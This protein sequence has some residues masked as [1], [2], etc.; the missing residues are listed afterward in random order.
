MQNPTSNVN[1]RKILRADALWLVAAFVLGTL[2]GCLT[3]N[4]NMTLPEA[5]VQR[6]T[7]DYVRDLYRAK[8]KGKTSAPETAPSPGAAAGSAAK[9]SLLSPL[10]SIDLIAHAH[11]GDDVTVKLGGKAVEQIKERQIARMDELNAQKSAGLIGENNEGKLAF[12]TPEK[13][14]KIDVMKKVQKLVA[15]ENADRDAL[16]KEVLKANNAD[17][18]K[19]ADIQKS[20]ARSFQVHSPAGTWIQ[21]MDSNWVRKP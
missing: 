6:A 20:F 12:R 5:A 2:P 7:D 13:T 3:L 15:D 9:T 19:L 18:S 8:E 4:V 14:P 17:K 10:D 16:Y 21:D 11:A 1:L